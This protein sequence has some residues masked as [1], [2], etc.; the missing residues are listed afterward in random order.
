[1][2]TTINIHS[3]NEYLILVFSVLMIENNMG[4]G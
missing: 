2:T 4:V 3:A 1:M